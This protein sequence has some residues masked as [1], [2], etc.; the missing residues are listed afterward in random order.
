MKNF[1]KIILVCMVFA[2]SGWSQDFNTLDSSWES[3]DLNLALE[4]NLTSLFADSDVELFDFAG[5]YDSS[6]SIVTLTKV[7]RKSQ[8]GEET[9]K[10]IISGTVR[11]YTI[12]FN[13]PEVSD[14]NDPPVND[15]FSLSYK[16]ALSLNNISAPKSC[17]AM[18]GGCSGLTS[19]DLRGFDTRNVTSMTQMFLNCNGF[20]S[21]DLSGFD[22]AKVENM[23]MMFMYCSGL[24]SLNLSGFDTSEV[25]NM[26]DMFL[27]CNGLTSLDLSGFDTGKVTNM[28]SMFMNCSG[29]TS[30]NSSGFDTAKVENMGAMFM[31][32][33][34][35]AELDLSS[36]NTAKVKAMNSMFSAC[37]KLKRLD[38]SGF[39]TE[40]VKNINSMFGSCD[41]LTTLIVAPSFAANVSNDNAY[42]NNYGDVFN[43]YGGND[44]ITI[45]ST[46]TGRTEET[47]F[48]EKLRSI[49]SDYSY[50]QLSLDRP[51]GYGDLVISGTKNVIKAPKGSTEMIL[52]P[53]VIVRFDQNAV[54]KNCGSIRVQNEGKAYFKLADPAAPA[55]IINAGGFERTEAL[56]Y[57]AFSNA[58]YYIPSENGSSFDREHIDVQEGINITTESSDLGDRTDIIGDSGNIVVLATSS[59]AT[60]PIRMTNSGS[61]SINVA[62][63]LA[64]DAGSTGMSA[65]DIEVRGKFDIA[66]NLSKFNSGKFKAENAEVNFTNPESIPQTASEF[67]NSTVTYPDGASIT[68][69]ITS[70]GGTLELGGDIEDGVTIE[71]KNTNS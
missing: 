23:G 12:V 48:S 66:G 26:S 9:A 18:F 49:V 13:D 29:L 34:N 40:E 70:T 35:L 46:G 14:P 20:T 42:D 59:G 17:R 58:T 41:D 43:F 56:S 67:V 25:T 38:I 33:C 60:D 11:S 24:T 45:Y 68:E 10:L 47:L 30:L 44:S 36:F 51:E 2:T 22:T 54:L 52:D 65:L 31:N 16:V 37:S 27:N 64:N 55:T 71:L 4:G 53:G 39:N 8:R 32:C 57:P 50:V 19:L 61:S 28:H 1:M 21:L 62:A 3:S 6:N 15:I 7:T 69:D 63:A 5:N